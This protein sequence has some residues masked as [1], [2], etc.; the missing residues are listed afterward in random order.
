M[1]DTSFAPFSSPF[2]CHQGPENG[3]Q[4]TEKEVTVPSHAINDLDIYPQIGV[5]MWVNKSGRRPFTHMALRDVAVR[6]AKV[7]AKPYKL[8]DEH[9]LYVRILPKGGKYW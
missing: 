6:N 5:K 8:S 7:R 1:W 4:S 9:G 2:R 3:F